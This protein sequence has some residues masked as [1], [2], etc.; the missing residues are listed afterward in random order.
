MNSIQWPVGLL[1][2]AA[3]GSFWGL[4]NVLTVGSRKRAGDRGAGD[5]SVCGARWLKASLRAVQHNA[6]ENVAHITL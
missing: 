5:C 3:G 4:P 1:Q 6:R 2:Q